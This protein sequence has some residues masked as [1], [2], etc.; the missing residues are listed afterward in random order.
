MPRWACFICTVLAFS[1]CATSPAA[2]HASAAD[3]S[4]PS[5]PPAAGRSSREPPT[6][7]AAIPGACRRMWQNAGTPLPSPVRSSTEC[8]ARSR[9]VEREISALLIREVT[10]DDAQRVARVDFPCLTVRSSPGRVRALAVE[11]H[12]G[13]ARVIGVE[14]NG[15]GGFRARVL[16]VS[17]GG[18]PNQAAPGP[19]EFFRTD[20]SEAAVART[21][22]RMRV[23]LGARVT[24][25]REP[26][27]ADSRIDLG[28]VGMSS[29]NL[30]LELVLDD[31]V[32]GTAVRAWQGYRGT[33]DAESRVPIEVAWEM[34]S[35]TAVE[36]NASRDADPED[37]AL[38]RDV[39]LHGAANFDRPWY[40]TRGLL[41]LASK[42]GS[43][44]LIPEL[45]EQLSSSDAEAQR[46]A[47]DALAAISGLDIRRDA[48]G[49]RRTL[50]ELVGE[51]RRECGP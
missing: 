20:L 44:E 25:E 29:N 12:G 34:L 17:T 7:P 6:T 46:L 10:G 51:Y 11:G 28:A 4:S 18:G 2:S 41:L 13:H 14:P 16:R 26:S 8:V 30:S 37:R 1:G 15:A 39:W 27:V 24:T 19:V 38:L 42:A 33:L 40:A 32:G 21:F 22:E 43:A 5:S 45:V 23:V 35:R 47:I 36:R 3:I 31:A 9:D 48:T 49:K 50:S